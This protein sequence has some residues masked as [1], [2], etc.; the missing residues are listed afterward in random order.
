[1]SVIAIN[2]KSTY[3]DE[4]T[5]KLL[6]DNGYDGVYVSQEEFEEF[7][8]KSIA[9]LII[10]IDTVTLDE[11]YIYVRFAKEQ[12]IDTVVCAETPDHI[13]LPLLFRHELRG[14]LIKESH[15][16]LFIQKI[17]RLK[18]ENNYIDEAIVPALFRDYLRLTKYSLDRPQQLLTDRE[19]EILEL[20]V[21]GKTTSEMGTALSI[22]KK[23]VTNHIASILQKLQVDD[24]INAALLALKN[25]WIIL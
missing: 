12:R 22:S 21:Q 4:K 16:D 24:R 1:M 6:K 14:Y 17:K 25:K 7:D 19:W 15:K 18:Y 20:I 23:T 9:L 8:K 13:E 10:D 5:I 2:N 3:I 11:L